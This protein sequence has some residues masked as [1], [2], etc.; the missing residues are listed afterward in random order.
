MCCLQYTTTCKPLARVLWDACDAARRHSKGTSALSGQPWYAMP[1]LVA[2][3]LT[4]CM[5]VVQVSLCDAPSGD[6]A[7]AGGDTD[8]AAQALRRARCTAALQLATWLV[9]TLNA[10]EC[11]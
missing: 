3:E 1:Q 9:E 7:D 5:C 10:Y 4:G 6:T 8:S 2:V 11:V